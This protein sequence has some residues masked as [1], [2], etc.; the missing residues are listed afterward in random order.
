[1]SIV[2]TVAARARSHGPGAAVALHR[3]APQLMASRMQHQKTIRGHRYPVYCLAFD[4][5]GRLLISGSD[6]RNVKVTLP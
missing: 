5:T 2:S 4:R 1:M 6:D 3:N